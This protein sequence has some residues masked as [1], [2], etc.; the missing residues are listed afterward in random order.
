MIPLPYP[1]RRVDLCT[2]ARATIEQMVKRRSER[3]RKMDTILKLKEKA[4]RARYVYYIVHDPAAGYTWELVGPDDAQLCS[5]RTFHSKEE[6]L[7][8]LRVV[9]RQASTAPI[10]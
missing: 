1:Q 8:S 5:G 2:V 7:K 6:C 3:L 4:A 10:H 9:Q